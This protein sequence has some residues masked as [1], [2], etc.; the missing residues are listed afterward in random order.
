MEKFPPG[1]PGLH[2]NGAIGASLGDLQLEFVGQPLR[3][4]PQ[5]F[6]DVLKVACAGADARDCEQLDAFEGLTITQTLQGR[7]TPGHQ[8]DLGVPLC[9]GANRGQQLGGASLI[10][11]DPRLQGGNIWIAPDLLAAE[12]VGTQ[13]DYGLP[14]PPV[15]FERIRFEFQLAHEAGDILRVR[16][17]KA[18][19]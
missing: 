2:D 13:V 14:A 17:A 4:P 8:H 19:Y 3:K 16:L 15:R 9:H 7:M 6:L 18:I 11:E 5:A 10:F 1:K 12:N